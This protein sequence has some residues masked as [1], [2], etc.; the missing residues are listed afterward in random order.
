MRSG[1]MKKT[2]MV[3]DDDPSIIIS[4]EQ[5]LK[6]INE[7]YQVLGAKSGEELFELLENN[8]IPDLILLDIGMPGMNGWQVINKLREKR[9]W[10]KIPVVFLTAKT[11]TFSKTFG[12]SIAWDYITKPFE[13]R[14]LERRIDNILCKIHNVVPI[15]N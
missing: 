2:I 12:R 9:E 5:G 13:A 7:E 6:L 10:K 15:I 4:I 14:E 8:Q 3:V 11:D 1:K